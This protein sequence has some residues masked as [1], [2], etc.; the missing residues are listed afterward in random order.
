[1]RE[2]LTGRKKWDPKVLGCKYPCNMTVTSKQ[3]FLMDSL[4]ITK[5]DSSLTKYPRLR[6]TDSLQLGKGKG[7]PDNLH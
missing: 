6:P 7:F 2:V 4:L 5:I 1:M 3:V